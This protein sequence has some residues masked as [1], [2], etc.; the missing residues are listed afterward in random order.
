MKTIDNK[1]FVQYARYDLTINRTFYRNMAIVTMALIAAVTVLGFMLRW[2]ALSS[3]DYHTEFDYRP[4]F[5]ALMVKSLVGIIQT[6]WAGCVN[7]PLRNKQSRISVLTLPATNAEK[8]LW[9]LLLVIVG[10]ML[11]CLLSVVVADGL[12]ALLSL[13]IGLSP[14]EIYSLTAEHLRYYTLTMNLPFT[15]STILD[16]ETSA[17]WGEITKWLI[18][19]S[20]VSAVWSLSAFVFGNAVKYKYNIIWTFIALYALQ[21]VITILIII[22][23]IGIGSNIDMSTIRSEEINEMAIVRGIFITTIILTVVTSALMW[24][25]SWRLYKKAQITLCCAH[26]R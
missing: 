20:A 21:M 1:R 12:N 23:A 5:T 6:I 19:T 18:A 26:I 13:M 15:E 14:S 17:E 7:H 24:W 16:G 2:V 3:T 8:Y 22:S 10:A 4:I 11:L 25:G 9:H